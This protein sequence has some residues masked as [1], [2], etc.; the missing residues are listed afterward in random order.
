M[1]FINFDNNA[2]TK[3]CPEALEVMSEAYQFSYNPSANHSLGR[4][5]AMIVENARMNVSEA[6]NA[7]NYEIFFTG[8]GTEANNMALFSDKYEKIL[9]AKIEHSS[10]YNVRPKNTEIT[11]IPTDSNGVID[12]E[13]FK[14]EI[15][16][17]NTSNFLVSIMYANS[18]AGIIQ[19][20]K[21]IAKIVH[22]KG[23]LIHSD[24]VQACG[25]ITVDLED[26]NVD[27]ATISAHKINGPQ[28]VGALLARRGLDIEPIIYG[29]GQENGKRSGTLNVA[30]IA[31]LGHCITKIDEKVVK[32][33]EI[34]KIRDYIEEEV[35]KI[36]GENVKFFGKGVDRVKNTSFFAIKNGDS[37]TQLIHF[38]LNKIMVSGGSACS[39]GSTKAP[40]ILE[41]MNV[42][43]DFKGALRV[44]LSSENNFKEADLFIAAFKKYYEKVSKN[45]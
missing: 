24:M 35:T 33:S 22:Q 32:M 9:F 13:K 19:P 11:E 3:L 27:F 7:N 39:S 36:A 8:G 34:G 43:E 2:T 12:L 45:Y 28:G 42:T 1:S 26:L 15:S 20:I 30:G 17:T 18:E 14:D 37:Q 31:G 16:R 40:K 5:A 6:L 29:G 23:G 38:D 4:Q 44:S 10:V 25:K 21:E 41:A